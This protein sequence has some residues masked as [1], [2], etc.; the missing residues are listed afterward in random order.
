VNKRTAA[1]TPSHGSQRT[2]AYQQ[3]LAYVNGKKKYGPLIVL[4][5]GKFI[6]P[7]EK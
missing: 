4:K 5:L 7:S 6:M 2:G 3:T 1:T